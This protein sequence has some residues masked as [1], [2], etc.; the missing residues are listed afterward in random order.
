MSLLSFDI[1]ASKF[2]FNLGYNGSARQGSCQG[3]VLTFLSLLIILSY[4]IYLLYLYF[5]NLIDAKYRFQNF[6]TQERLDVPLQQNLISFSFQYTQNQTVD[7]YQDA[8]NKTYLV[9]IAHFY[10]QQNNITKIIDLD[11]VRCKDP[12]LQGFNCIDFSKVSNYT[13]Y[14]DPKK[15]QTSMVILFF[16]GCQDVDKIKK[17]VPDNCS[18]QADIDDLVDNS[19]TTLKIKLQTQQLNTTSKQVQINYRNLQNYIQSNSQLQILLKL[20]T[21]KTKVNQRFLY[22]TQQTFSSPISFVQNTQ[23]FHKLK[24]LKAGV[25]PYNNILLLIDEIEQD[26]QITYPTITEIF[27]LVNSF[28]TIFLIL[29]ALGKFLSQ[30]LIKQDLFFLIQKNLFQ[31]IIKN[32]LIDQVETDYLFKYR[33]LNFLQQQ[34]QSTITLQKPDNIQAQLKIQDHNEINQNNL[35]FFDIF[36]SSKYRKKS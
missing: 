7:Q 19:L 21:Q 8:M 22:Q 26:V 30:K 31:G 20:Q 15:T 23:N 27:A 4:L 24:S 13:L 18:R 5:N 28:T 29:K 36:G 14:F 35:D 9:Y 10:Y 33:K 17:T 1:F 11:I 34:N 12:E 6:I 32:K 3:L 25:G 16:Y 2:Q